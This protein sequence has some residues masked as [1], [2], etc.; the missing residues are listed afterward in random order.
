MPTSALLTRP[1]AA[2]WA[3]WNTGKPATAPSPKPYGFS[4]GPHVGVAWQITPKTVFR[5][6]GAINYAAGPD[7]AG[8]NVSVAGLPGPDSL[9]GY[10]LPAAILKN[11]D[12]YAP[13]NVYG[14]PVLTLQYVLSN[15]PAVPAGHV[16]PASCLP[17]RR[18][19][20]SLPMP[21]AFPESS[22]GASASSARLRKT[23]WWKLPTW[24]IAALGGPRR[25]CP[26]LNYN[27]VSPQ[28]LQSKYGLNVQNPVDAAALDHADQFAQ[29]D[30]PLPEFGESE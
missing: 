5:A 25:C 3:Q 8:L 6:G 22:S 26:R 24:A 12:P 13:G 4:I 7:Q 18:L 29:R 30:R 20:P 28:Q 27:G 17:A 14:N 11:G 2:G 19:F 10:G 16:L 23:W 21:R 1:S 9:P 15:T